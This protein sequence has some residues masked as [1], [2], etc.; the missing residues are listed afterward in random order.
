MYNIDQSKKHF[1][2]NIDMKYLTNLSFLLILILS[3]FLFS[4]NSSNKKT[5]KNPS[6]TVSIAPVAEKVDTTFLI[7]DTAIY[8]S[9]IREIPYLQ[10]YYKDLIKEIP[11]YLYYSKYLNHD[12]AEGMTIYFLGVR[13][14][15]I[16]ENLDK[17]IPCQGT[18]YQ[19]INGF[20]YIGSEECSGFGV[21]SKESYLKEQ[22][23]RT[24]LIT[25]RKISFDSINMLSEMGKERDAVV[26]IIMEQ[27]NPKIIGTEPSM[28][29]TMECLLMYAPGTTEDTYMEINMM[30]GRLRSEIAYAKVVAFIRKNKLY[31]KKVAV[32]YG[33]MHMEDF[34][35]IANVIK[36][37]G[38]YSVPPSCQ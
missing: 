7:K 14:M 24:S 2:K 11:E 36:V 18:I 33:A 22:Q 38:Q 35:R 34:N 5:S 25:K 17:L 10:K 15:S 9:K 30:F 29:Y 4:C 31:D 27:D 32:V 26:K 12:S 6:P 13:H 19:M 16:H 8:L 37:Y 21:I 23:Y 20:D 1:K 28:L 3:N